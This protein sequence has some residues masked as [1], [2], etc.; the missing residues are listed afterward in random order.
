MRS[1]GLLVACLSAVG[2]SRAEAEENVI[3]ADSFESR[4]EITTPASAG[5]AGA[6]GADLPIVERRYNWSGFYAGVHGGY[7][8]SESMGATTSSPGAVAMDSTKLSG[9]FGGGQIGY[10]WQPGSNFVVGI[11]ADAAGSNLRY[12]EA[13]GARMFNG[14]V[15]PVLASTAEISALG[16][17]TG[18]LGYAFG[19]ALVYAKGGWGWADTNFSMTMFDLTQEKSKFLSGWTAGAGL[20]YGF[21]SSWSVK[22]EYQYFDFGSIRYFRMLDL[23]TAVHTFKGGV[24]YRF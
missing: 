2:F 5:F 15:F 11:E 14:A 24:N 6:Y 4:A 13:I 20:E 8:W 18:R 19:P 17:V 16:S 22:G 21:A 7:A 1:F 12:K 23:S 3:P 9:G 10:N